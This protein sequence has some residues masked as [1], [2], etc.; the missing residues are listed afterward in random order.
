MM[1]DVSQ[2]HLKRPD[3]SGWAE[4]R[5]PVTDDTAHSLSREN[6]RHIRCGYGKCYGKNGWCGCGGYQ[7]QAG[8]DFCICG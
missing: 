3:N 4:H 2:V 8:N 6:G 5:F 1:L 7:K